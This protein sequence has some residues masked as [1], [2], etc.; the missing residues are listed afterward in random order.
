[1]RERHFNYRP[2][3]GP[4][5]FDE[6]GC[7]RIGQGGL[8]RPGDWVKVT[9]YA[10]GPESLVRKLADQK[11]GVDPRTTDIFYVVE[12]QGDGEE[13]LRVRRQG[14]PTWMGENL[15]LDGSA[16]SPG[17]WK[18]VTVFAEGWAAENGGDGGHVKT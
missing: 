15:D 10:P 1:M 16:C 9:I 14:T 17:K 2:V 12:L 5:L 18:T 13:T 6:S 3:A 8:H 7:L 11:R 4:A